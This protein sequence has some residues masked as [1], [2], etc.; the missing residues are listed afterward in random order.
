VIR[1]KGFPPELSAIFLYPRD[2]DL[3]AHPAYRQA[4]AGDKSAALE[5]VVEL[6]ATW[7]YSQRGSFKPGLLFVAPHALEATGDNAI[8]QTLATVCAAL[9]RGEVDTEIVQTDKVYHTGADPME[10]MAA[11]AQFEGHV[12]PGAEYVLV[13][14]V[15]NLG[16]TLAELA[17]FIQ[18]YGG[19][20]KRVLVLVNA[21]RDTALVPQKKFVRLIKERFDEKFTDVF[22][23][24]PSALTANEAQYLVGL[25]SI[26]AIR[27][28]L[29]AAEQEIDRR[30]RSK[31]IVRSVEATP[32]GAPAE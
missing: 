16:G 28:R 30:L 14:D 20:I 10:R 17:N 18:I 11:R 1:S 7:L 25:K 19:V 12:I 2:A 31:G 29:A 26:D 21:G 22:G 4:K 13:D 3:K 8:P 6:A 9:Y 23:I 5:L 27:N 24:E 15:T 32:L